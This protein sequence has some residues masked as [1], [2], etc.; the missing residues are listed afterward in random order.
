MTSPYDPVDK[1]RDAVQRAQE[2]WDKYFGSK[3]KINF[4]TLYAKFKYVKKCH[5][6]DL[7]YLLDFNNTKMVTKQSWVSAMVRF[8]P[9]RSFAR[10][11]KTIMSMK[12]FYGYISPPHSAKLLKSSGKR[13]QYIVRLNIRRPHKIHVDYLDKRSEDIR[14][15]DVYKRKDGYGYLLKDKTFRTERE[16]N[17]LI[18]ACNFLQDPYASS[19]SRLAFFH[20][21]I[22]SQQAE[23]LLS[24][25]G[26][27]G[28]YL[29]RFS[30]S[31]TTSLALTYLDLHN[32]ICHV[33]IEVDNGVYTVSGAPYSDLTAML[34]SNPT[35]Q[36]TFVQPLF[37][38]QRH[39]IVNTRR[40]KRR[41]S[42]K[43]PT[44]SGDFT[45]NLREKS[46]SRSN[47]RLALDDQPFLAPVELPSPLGKPK[48]RP[49]Q[50]RSSPPSPKPSA[51]SMD[52]A[53]YGRFPEHKMQS[54]K[55]FGGSDAFEQSSG[56]SSMFT[57]PK[58][59]P[60]MTSQN[61]PY[62]SVP[63][64]GWNPRGGS[65]SDLFAYTSDASDEPNCLDADFSPHVH[66]SDRANTRGS[67]RES[68]SNSSSLS[69][70]SPRERRFDLRGSAT[71]VIR[72]MS[73]ESLHNGGL[74]SGSVTKKSSSSTS[75]GG[76]TGAQSD[77]SDSSETEEE[78]I[79]R[80]RKKEKRQVGEASS[81]SE[82]P[83]HFTSSKKFSSNVK[84]SG[85]KSHVFPESEDDTVPYN[86]VGARTPQFSYRVKETV[87]SDET[88]S[89]R[90]SESGVLS[91]PADIL[92]FMQALGP[93]EL[94][95]IDSVLIDMLGLDMV[96]LRSFLRAVH[97]VQTKQLRKRG[98][99]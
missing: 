84:P 57:T 82:M 74:H 79:K 92:P 35:A 11:V 1:P 91:V 17:M 41:D 94:E 89:E 72:P 77:V 52:L 30:S 54:P 75:F 26:N 63:P 7:Q 48:T 44:K 34:S 14:T 40:S 68:V 39:L 59:A 19:H 45:N 73:R 20:G 81:D 42:T 9:S 3:D 15:L 64:V 69:S 5:R 87:D 32:N 46:T 2:N 24:K 18:Q 55:S 25:E 93:K 53:D 65:T 21:D 90:S 50:K 12:G 95:K 58:E 67:M 43:R 23:K 22:S 51:E 60:E 97:K 96:K 83:V 33:K 13:G 29:V 31:S 85:S 61:P 86:L 8:G 98:D 62:A 47:V 37:T 88:Y 4:D 49:L 56:S 10:N 27:P 70:R 6:S 80:P 78:L 71:K 16:L 38:K 36:K 28:S 76:I 66:R 99:T